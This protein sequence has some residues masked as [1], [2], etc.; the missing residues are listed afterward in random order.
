VAA[1]ASLEKILLYFT[2]PTYVFDHK[3]AEDL[4]LRLKWVPAF[5][6]RVSGDPLREFLRRR[7][8]G[9]PSETGVNVPGCKSRL[10]ELLPELAKV[11]AHLLKGAKHQSHAIKRRDAVLTTRQKCD[12][13]MAVANNADSD[14]SPLA[15]G[16]RLL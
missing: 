4:Q 2:S 8:D 16:Q 12:E 6:P 13:L 14:S 3:L 9:R 11:V 7:L 10:R 1:V 15:V 5:E